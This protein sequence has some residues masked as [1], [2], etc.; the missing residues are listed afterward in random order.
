M[1]HRNP[2]HS[3]HDNDENVA[4]PSE[5]TQHEL[6]SGAQILPHRV[7]PD[8]TVAELLDEQFQAYNAARLHEAARLYVEKMLA[9]EQDV[10][11]GMTMAG[12]L[13]PAGLGGCILTLLE[14]GFV[15]FI[16]STGA[17][18]YHDIHHALAMTLH[19][20]DFRQ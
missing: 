10:T 14:N 16:I 2:H 11:I 6:L 19:R 1:P 8:M 3:E 17:N 7:R 4:P 9:P 13:T 15:D 12:A 18:L 20:G 5:A